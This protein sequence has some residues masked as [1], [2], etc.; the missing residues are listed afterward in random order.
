MHGT[1]LPIPWLKDRATRRLPSP[2]EARGQGI[3]AV[4]T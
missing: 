2:L 1:P 3:Q 4:A